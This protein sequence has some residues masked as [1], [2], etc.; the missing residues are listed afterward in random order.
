MPLSIRSL[1]QKSIAFKRVGSTLV[2]ASVENCFFTNM[3]GPYAGPPT[4]KVLGPEPG[5]FL[6]FDSRNKTDLDSIYALL[7]G[8]YQEKSTGLYVTPQEVYGGL[9]L[10]LDLHEEGY[11]TLIAEERVA[12]SGI[13]PCLSAVAGGQRQCATIGLLGPDSICL[14]TRD[15]DLAST[16]AT[17]GSSAPFELGVRRHG[18]N[19]QL[20]ERLVEQVRAW[21]VAGRPSNDGLRIRA[22]P[23]SSG[24]APSASEFVVPKRWTQLVVDRPG[25]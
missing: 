25:I 6:R 17:D 13:V 4:M 2:S 7:A 21:D 8:D 3:R 20:A 11:C 16:R 24:Y 1:N 9:A 12:D 19:S 23:S 15:R 22:Y 18:P 14:V 5:L 10:W